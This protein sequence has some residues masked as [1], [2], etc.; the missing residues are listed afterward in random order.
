MQI[1]LEQFKTVEKAFALLPHGEEFNRLNAETQETITNA[2]IALIKVLQRYKKEK[3]HT[4][5]VI[6]ERR[7]TNKNYARGRKYANN[8]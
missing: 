3:K 5:E 4:A 8:N 2:E 1:T 6:A 7:K